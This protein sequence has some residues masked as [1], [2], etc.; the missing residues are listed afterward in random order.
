[1]L[2]RGAWNGHEKAGRHFLEHQLRLLAGWD[3]GDI[4]LDPN[5]CPRVFLN[6][7]P[8]LSSGSVWVMRIGMCGRRGKR[9]VMPSLPFAGP[10]TLRRPFE[11]NSRSYTPRPS[12]FKGV[13]ACRF[14]GPKRFKLARRPFEGN[15]RSYTPRPADY[16]RVRA[17]R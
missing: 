11:G 14:P 5:S 3:G 10:E 16:T 4:F 7:P 1:V 2:P 8:G 17:S 13:Q 15:S 6:N 9:P 12:V